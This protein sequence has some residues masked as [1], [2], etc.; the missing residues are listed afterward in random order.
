MGTSE[1]LKFV[2]KTLS[3]SLCQSVM[4]CSFGREGGFLHKPSVSKWFDIV[5]LKISLLN[6]IVHDMH[7]KFRVSTLCSVASCLSFSNRAYLGCD[8]AKNISHIQV[9]VISFI[10]SLPIKL[11]LGLPIGGRDYSN[12]KPPGPISI[13]QI[14]FS[15]LSIL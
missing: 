7:D 2:N 8:P 12:S 11:M 13:S 14:I 5:I 6:R 4:S 10:P 1:L 15:T 9:S 3:I